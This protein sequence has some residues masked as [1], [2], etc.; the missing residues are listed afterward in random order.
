MAA[1][2]EQNIDLKPYN[3]FHVQAFARFFVR[4]ESVAQI[5]WLIQQPVFNENKRFILGGGS[6]CVFVGDFNGLVIKI[7]THG[8]E[9]V[10]ENNEEVLVK[11]ASGE[12]W[13]DFVLHCLSKNWGGVE[14]LSLIPGTVGA[15]PIQNIGAYGIEVKDLI[16]RVD[17][18]DLRDGAEHSFSNEE[19]KFSYR[20]SIFKH[21]WS[22]NIFIS[23]V[24]LRLR[25]KNHSINTS[26]GALKE[27][28]IKQNITSPSIHDVSQC[29]IAI[30][31]SKLP[32]P[33]QL[34]NAGSFFKNPVIDK[35]LLKKLQVSYPEIPNYKSDNQLVKLPAGWL[36]E[37]AGW[38]GK[39]FNHVGVHHQQALVI[40][41][42]HDASGEEIFNL[43]QQIIDDVNEKFNIQLTREVNIIA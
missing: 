13:H 6:N 19:C 12:V 35:Q 15:A 5:K 20:E 16:E 37:K 14:N 29:V 18:I 32:D 33:T 21:A 22:K 11:V 4:I 41:N 2:I 7:E 1:I 23:S 42:H 30:R 28:L 40:V 36:I 34:G 39:R 3:T 17:A 9:V 43:S 24:T 26:Y 25:T 27:Q 8:I 38:K 10:Q 31:R